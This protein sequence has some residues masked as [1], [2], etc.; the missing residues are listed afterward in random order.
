MIM[1]HAYHDAKGSSCRQRRNGDVCMKKKSKIL[2]YTAIVL[3][4][5]FALTGVPYFDKIFSTSAYT[6]IIESNWGIDLPR[7]GA[8][9][10]YSFSEPSF[11]GDGIRYHVIDYPIGNESK[12]IANSVFQLEKVFLGA[13]KPTED[14]VAYVEALL[15]ETEIPQDEIPIWNECVLVSQSQEDGSELY[16]FYGGAT[17]TVYVVESFL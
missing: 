7:S 9:E 13:S 16:L 10:V 1:G 6:K 2:I 15:A 4:A 8:K 11:H 12:R 14:Q 17:G 5:L 3:C